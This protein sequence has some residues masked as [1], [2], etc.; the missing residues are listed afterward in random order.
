MYTY[1]TTTRVCV[2]KTL[3]KNQ[4]ATYY[5]KH[6]KY[7]SITIITTATTTLISSTVCDANVLSSLIR[8]I[9]SV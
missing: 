5:G 2:W 3:K 9:T 6:L 1:T 7:A 4:E 8:G